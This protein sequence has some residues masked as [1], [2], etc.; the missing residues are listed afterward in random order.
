MAWFEPQPESR[1]DTASAPHLTQE[2]SNT[3]KPLDQPQPEQPLGLQNPQKAE[4]NYAA[5]RALWRK[6]GE[7]E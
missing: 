6:M 5:K 1:G 4:G 2:M 7:V 3:T